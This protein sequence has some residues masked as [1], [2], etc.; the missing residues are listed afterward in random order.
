MQLKPYNRRILTSDVN[1]S[2]DDESVDETSFA[3]RGMSTQTLSTHLETNWN[4]S[5]AN[6]SQ[7]NK[8]LQQAFM[9][10][11]NFVNDLT[12]ICVAILTAEGDKM[13]F[14]EE[15]LQKMNEGLPATAYVPVLSYAQRNYMILKMVPDECRLFFTATKAPYLVNIEVF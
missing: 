7:T 13:K 5:L 8:Y 4:R 14:L 2:K 9:S 11:P 12:E 1:K 6:D 15:S 3:N 10:T